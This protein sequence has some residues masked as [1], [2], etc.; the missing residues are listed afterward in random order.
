MEHIRHNIEQRVLSALDEIRIYLQE[1]GGDVEFVNC[2]IDSGILNIK[3][4]GNCAL[5]PMSEMT[6]RAGIER[7]IKQKI[8][9]ITRIERVKSK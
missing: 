3:L 8:P 2:D 6:L 1:D 7:F 4:T 5:C 9:V